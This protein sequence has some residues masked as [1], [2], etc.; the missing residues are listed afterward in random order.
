[1]FR[2]ENWEEAADELRFSGIGWV[3]VACFM[4]LIGGVWS[5]DALA[6]MLDAILHN[7][8][9][10]VV[11]VLAIHE[12]WSL[13][14]FVGGIDILRKNLAV[15]ILRKVAIL[16]VLCTFGLFLI[17]ARRSWPVLI[18]SMR[19]HLYGAQRQPNDK[20]AWIELAP[21]TAKGDFALGLN[22]LLTYRG[23]P[24]QGFAIPNTAEG[25]WISPQSSR[26]Y[27][28][29][30]TLEDRCSKGIVIDLNA[31][32]GWVV[33]DGT[34]MVTGFSAVEWTRWSPDGE[35]LLAAQYYEAH[36]ELYVIAIGSRKVSR[37][38]INLASPREEQVYLLDSVAWTSPRTFTMG[39][40]INCNPYTVDRC[41]DT[42]RKVPLRAY[43]IQA[44]VVTLEV[45][46]TTA[47]PGLLQKT[48]ATR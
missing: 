5:A 43:T 16:A 10:S 37:I 2:K 6:G 28:F 7:P 17:V 20:V 45:H 35:S 34:R 13:A 9:F 48:S 47:T 27:A 25:I 21:G 41:D 30:V 40:T 42:T 24:F 32:T 26:G 38:P 8:M 11:L 19:E 14:L 22:R 39:L 29:L 44:D 15:A 12:S 18:D 33:L 3:F 1:V 46:H 31:L 23:M 36:P 4:V